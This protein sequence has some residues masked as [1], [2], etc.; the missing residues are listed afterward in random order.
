M[1]SFG[2]GAKDRSSNESSV[3]YVG[4]KGQH[5][6]EMDS[7]GIPVPPGFIVPNSALSDFQEANGEEIS[8]TTK[9]KVQTYLD[10]LAKLS[11]GKYGDAENPLLIA[12]RSSSTYPMP[13]MM[14]TVL[15]VG[16]TDDTVKGI[17]KHTTERFAYDTYR[18]LIQTY[19]TIVIAG[20]TGGRR[21]RNELGRDFRRV[22]RDTIGNGEAQ[23]ERNLKPD[24]VHSMCEAYK[25]MLL[26]RHGILFPDDPMEQLFAAIHSVARSWSNARATKYRKMKGIPDRLGPSVIVQ[27]M[28]FGNYDTSSATG[29]LYTRNPSSGRKTFC[30]DWL[31]RAQ[32]DEILSGGAHPYP[33]NDDSRFCPTPEGSTLEEAMPSVYSQLC[34]IGHSLETHHRMVQEVEF[35]VQHHS[36]WILQVRDAQCTHLASFRVINDMNREGLITDLEKDRRILQLSSEDAVSWRQDSRD[37]TASASRSMPIARGVPVSH[38]SVTGTMVL[39]SEDAEEVAGRSKGRVV[40]VREHVEPEDING[41]CAASGVMASKGGFSSHVAVVCRGLNIPCI[42]GCEGLRVDNPKI[43]IGKHSLHER[44]PITLDAHEGCIYRGAENG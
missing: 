40:L 43:G 29:V 31:P 33:L 44:D 13:G 23:D 30:G 25:S 32:G 17:A 4:R 2:Y 7:M 39:T 26:S 20:P 38:G 27:A 21:L 19:S 10:G 15:N 1:Y 34:E 5:L 36:L 3:E 14:D 12:V 6:L 42:L 28:V 22:L 41:I 9:I 35:T 8:L 11:G 37:K 24:N 18:R 16:L